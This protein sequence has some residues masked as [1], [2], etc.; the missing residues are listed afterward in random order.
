MSCRSRGAPMS[1]IHALRGPAGQL[2]DRGSFVGSLR[3]APASLLGRTDEEPT[4]PLKMTDLGPWPDDPVGSSGS[5][6]AF[7]A[8]ER[9]RELVIGIGEDDL[10]AFLCDYT[11]LLRPPDIGEEEFAVILRGYADFLRT[12]R[13]PEE[14]S[15]LLKGVDRTLIRGVL[16]MSDD[17]LSVV[18]RDNNITFPGPT[19]ESESE[20]RLEARLEAVNEAIDRGLIEVVIEAFESGA[21]GRKKPGRK[22]RL[23]GTEQ[24]DKYLALWRKCVDVC[25]GDTDRARIKFFRDG[26]EKLNVTEGT[27]RNA[28]SRLKR[29]AAK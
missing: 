26:P 18:I 22:P 28:L 6:P 24:D 19:A 27:M 1:D 3:S 15:I 25:R 4:L 7:A 5:A 10:A 16:A 23:N 14:P 2:R 17:E 11:A 13:P 9:F 8:W 21:I 12:S 20:S 29:M